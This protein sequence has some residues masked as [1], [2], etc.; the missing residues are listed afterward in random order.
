MTDNELRAIADRF[1]IRELI[2][3]YS[4]LCTRKECDRLP[5]MFIEDCVWRTRGENKREFLGREAVVAAIRA[6]VEGYPLIVQMPH[7]PRIELAG[8]WA[9]ATTLMHEFGKLDAG[10]TA[11]TFAIYRDT[12]VRTAEGWKFAE[13]EFDASYQESASIPAD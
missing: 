7:A 13:R 11:F 9:T 5:D 10:T 2:D 6:V 8:D 3:E 1:L 12:L 4:N